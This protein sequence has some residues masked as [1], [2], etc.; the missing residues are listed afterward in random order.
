[1]NEIILQHDFK[2][3]YMNRFALLLIMSLMVTSTTSL[4]QQRTIRQQEFPTAL[5]VSDENIE[6]QR[7]IYRVINL[8][9]EANA[10]L[11][12]PPD[13]TEKHQGLFKTILHLLITGKVTVYAYP[14]DGN[15]TFSE[16][17]RIVIQDFLENYHIP[18]TKTDDGINVNDNDIPAQD[19]TMYYLKEG[20]YYDL[21]NS[22]FRT[23]VLALC[24]VIVAEDDF[25]DGYVRHPLFWI[26]YNDIEVYIKDLLVI[27]DGNVAQP[28]PMSDYFSL[29]KYSGNIY[30]VYNGHGRALTQYCETDSALNTE[31]QRITREIKEMKEWTFNTFSE[32]RNKLHQN[33]KKTVEQA[34]AARKRAQ[35]LATTKEQ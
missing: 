10:G 22:T 26:R 34:R 19:V 23:R 20:V 27:T 11:F 2:S 4:A 5:P 6:W 31:R 7:D 13:P 28:I 18:Y 17:T 16:N 35:S 3:H 33:T 1:M 14:L 24:P 21:S 32:K 30:K 12:C 29:N 8:L 25:G 9:D 15:E